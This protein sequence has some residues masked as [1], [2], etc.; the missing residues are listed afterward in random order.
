MNS[1]TNEDMIPAPDPAILAQMID[2]SVMWTDADA[3][4]SESLNAWLFH[5]TVRLMHR[6]L[7]MV[8]AMNA[9]LDEPQNAY[10]H[11]PVPYTAQTS[12]T[13][14]P[15]KK[16]PRKRFNRREYISENQSTT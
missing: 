10:F 2:N 7:A 15:Q 3:R 5:E 1:D 11:T 8:S 13:H 9:V 16:R 12:N 6:E 4:V 14:T